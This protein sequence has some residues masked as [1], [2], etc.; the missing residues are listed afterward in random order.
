M[1]EGFIKLDGQESPCQGP[2]K[3][4]TDMSKTVKV[5]ASSLERK[6]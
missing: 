4:L 6:D 1:K 2:T 3:T 5:N